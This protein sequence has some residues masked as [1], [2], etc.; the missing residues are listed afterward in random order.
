MHRFWVIQKSAFLASALAVLS[1][2]G[3]ASLLTQAPLVVPP[4]P[5]SFSYTSATATYYVGSSI[6]PNTN[7]LTTP[8]AYTYSSTPAL[9]TGLS[10]DPT[11]GNI[12]GIPQS[13]T[14]AGTYVITATGPDVQFAT[15]TIDTQLDVLTTVLSFVNAGTTA[16]PVGVAIPVTLTTIDPT[17]S[18]FTFGGL[19]VTF[20]VDNSAGG[21]GTLG[22]VTDNLDG[23]YTVNF[24]GMVLGDATI[25][26]SIGGTAI[27]S[28]WTFTVGVGP[29][30]QLAF[31]TQ[32][33]AS[34]QS[35][36]AFASQ[37]VIELRDLAGNLC[38]TA[39]NNVTL[40]I[41]NNAGTPAGVLSGTTTVAAVGGIATFAGLSIDKIGVGYT[42][43]ASSGAIPT[44]DSAALDITLGPMSTTVS[45]FV[46]DVPTVPAD[47]VTVANLTATILDA[48]GNPITGKDVQVTPSRAGFDIVT[49]A[50]VVTTNAS[51][52]ANFT[53]SSLLLG[54]GNFTA[55]NTTDSLT[56]ATNPAVTFTPGGVSAMLSTVVPSTMTPTADGLATTTVTVT[57]VDNFSNPVPGKTVILTSNRGPFDI[58]TTVAP[59]TGI[60]DA[61]GQVTFT[62]SSTTAGNSQL[63]ATDVTDSLP[64][65]SQPTL[66]FAP[67]TPSAAIS[68]LTATPTT[69][70]ADGVS[71][72]TATVTL[73]DAFSNPVPGKV[74]MLTST[75]GTVTPPVGIT[76]PTGAVSFSISSLAIG[77][78]MLAALDLTDSVALAANPTLTFTAGLPDTLASTVSVTPTT[79]LADGLTPSIVTVTLRDNLGNVVP[80]KTVSL[81]SDR[82]IDTITPATAVTNV[83]G[84]ALFA[85]RST[86]VGTS[87]YTATDTTDSIGIFQTATVTYNAAAVDPFT[88]TISISPATAPADGTL[89]NITVTLKDASGNVVA[90]KTVDVTSSRPPLTDT[91]SAPA[92]TDALGQATFTVSSLV[93]G[94]PTLTATDTT[95]SITVFSTAAPV[96]T[97]PPVSPTLSSV[98]IVPGS[99]VADG[100]LAT[101]TVT[102]LDT[103][104]NPVNGKT[105][106]ISSSRGGTDSISIISAVTAGAGQATFSI[107]SLMT[108]TASI[109]AIDVTDSIS[110]TTPGSV[111]FT[112]GPT[113][114]T[115]ST[116]S[117]TPLSV[118]VGASTSNVTVTL[119]D[120]NG[121][122]IPGVPVQLTSTGVATTITP[123]APTNTDALGVVTFT[124][125][126][127]TLGTAT[128]TA[129][130]TATPT[131]ISSSNPVITF[132]VG[133]TDPIASTVVAA[134][135]TVAADGATTSTITV[136]LRDSVGNP[137]AGKTVTLASS[138]TLGLD[139]IAPASAGSDI[140]D[141]AGVATFTVLSSTA[142]APDFFA[143]NATDSIAIT[144][145]ATVTFTAGA[146]SASVS[147][148]TA[149]S[150]TLAGDSTATSNLT[151][152]LKDAFGNPV[153]GKTV[154]VTSSRLSPPDTISAPVV[155]NAL[156]Q[157]TFTISANLV[158]TSLLTANDV[159]DGFPLSTTITLT[160]VPGAVH[161]GNST[162]TASLGSIPSDGIT[163][164]IITVTLRD[165]TGN[166]VPGKTV[167]TS[168]SRAGSDTLAPASAVTNAL[169]VANFSL[170]S[171]VPGTAIISAIGDLIPV[172]ATVS[173]AVNP[174]ITN[175]ITSTVT[176]SSPFVFADGIAFTTVTVTCRDLLGN[177]VPGST[178]TLASSRGIDMIAPASAVTNGAGVAS[179]QVSSLVSGAST[180]TATD[181]TSSVVILQTAAT[182]F[183]AGAPTAANS[184]VLATTATTVTADG[185]T[186]VSITVNLKDASMN[187]VAG[188]VVT[189]TSDR[190]AFDTIS[191]ALAASDINGDAFFTVKSAV[192]G[193]SIYSAVSNPGAIAITDNETATYTPGLTSASVSTAV[194]SPTSLLADGVATSTILVTI[195][196]AQSNVKPGQTVTISSDRAGLDTFPSGTS[197][198]TNASGQVSFTVLS[199]TAGLS[200]YTITDTTDGIPLSTSP[201]VTF[202]PGVTDAGTSTVVAAPATIKAD[203]T[204]TATVTVTLRD[205][206]SNLV[207]GKTVTL[208]SNRVEDTISP[209]S[210]VSDAAGVATFTVRSPRLGTATLTATDTTSAVVVTM[211]GS[212]TFTASKLIV[213][214]VANPINAD[215]LTDVTVTAQDNLGNTDTTYT[216]TVAFTSSDAAATLPANYLFTGPDA[217]VHTFTMMTKF[218]TSGAQSIT[219]TDTIDATITGS[220][221]FSVT[222]VAPSALTYFDAAPL[223]VVLSAIVPNTVTYSGGLVTNF[224]VSPALPAGLTLNAT[225]GV[226][227]GT[228]T[229]ALASAP[230]TITATNG[231]GFTTAVLNIATNFACGTSPGAMT[232]LPYAAGAGTPTNPYLLCSDI[233]VNQIGLN[234]SD[235]GASFK[236][237]GNI[238]LSAYDALTAPTTLALIG[239]GTY[240][241]SPTTFVPGT[242]FTGTFDGNGFTLSNL[243]IREGLTSNAAGLFRYTDGATIQN[244]TLSGIDV[245]G[246]AFVGGLIGYAKRTTITNVT[247][248]GQVQ[249]TSGFAN[250]QFAGGIAAFLDG[251]GAG[252]MS[253]VTGST[254]N[255]NVTANDSVGAVAGRNDATSGGTATI[256]T[257]SS[258]GN[259]AAVA[260]SSGWTFGGLVGQNIAG[261]GTA[262]VTTCTSNATVTSYGRFTG[263]LLGANSSSA[264]GNATVSGSAATGAVT[265][266]SNG[267]QHVGGLIGTNSGANSQVVSSLSTSTIAVNGTA[268]SFVGGL[269][270][271]NTPSAAG[272]TAVSL[273]YA[274][275]GIT[276]TG[277]NASS[278][279]GLVGL[280]TGSSLGSSANISRSYST[281]AVG[282]VSAGGNKV[283]GLIG[284][285]IAGSGAG[286]GTS[287]LY[288][289]Y[290]TST[291]TFGAGPA[292]STYAG[293]FVGQNINAAITD[294][295][296]RGNITTPS[297][298]SIGG[299]VGSNVAGTLTNTYASGSVTGTSNLGGLIGSD[300]TGVYTA[301]YW[302]SS[303]TATGVGSGPVAGTTGLSTGNM[304]L[305][306]NFIGWDFTT[307]WNAPGG[308]YLIL[309]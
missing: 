252:N 176:S 293:G 192:A 276:I 298:S 145:P 307:I 261:S 32:P 154:S 39:T 68:T 256:A 87:I 197:L 186:T 264:G 143:T 14:A 41:G 140:S 220:Q 156:G 279:G 149:S 75:L 188:Q 303:I 53:V 95:D 116:I 126:S 244:L 62:I 158:G 153:S 1:A 58:I 210:A 129:T 242:A 292:A 266:T 115:V 57:L 155:T 246:S 221:S 223:Y 237:M 283:G 305:Q 63:T 251:S 235:W 81:V 306:A 177:V 273:S 187:N 173:V 240:T 275:G 106:S 288:R 40:A 282:I 97:A 78:A 90:G 50:G 224:S 302:D 114:A 11:T 286:A 109:S 51:G 185:V 88:S 218:I 238:D 262:T 119:R 304:Y 49:P 205:I 134:P 295:Y 4:G 8:A 215:T 249:D 166:V 308:A 136:T 259:V 190:G 69:L 64:L 85:V 96:F 226:I 137:V 146:V 208:A 151:V 179:F 200:T 209:A 253:S 23:T 229:I 268:V 28:S 34:T 123:A 241:L 183:T 299:L 35:A 54:I 12:I 147:T 170:T 178:V 67:G 167:T 107:S 124:V 65:T 150:T 18:Q 207:S 13:L 44:S 25:T 203:D 289:S 22:A 80:G 84:V 108:G 159:T 199:S 285:N 117:A 122:V 74:V 204:T 36:T 105:V 281:G 265:V 271:S 297:G 104:S 245:E 180:F 10:I 236:M 131:I 16:A 280:N 160:W 47:G 132:V 300:V 269:L 278:I 201:T 112:P 99:I 76:G 206:T 72:S 2:C 225:T 19:P 111:S 189:L 230:Y 101:V 222:E 93:A 214:G 48:G 157:A 263:G 141:A 257:T 29:P 5:L 61:L 213:A 202:S 73:L 77:T 38:T 110:I 301:N 172:T 46:S 15:V 243:I 212:V 66:A 290:S 113:S 94:T 247:V 248:A 70:F 196:D 169:G 163:P 42:L 128:L 82:G 254:A 228:P 31:T 272:T 37:P 193:T 83:A 20:A 125:S 161:A 227:T 43:R 291:V 52:V 121:N 30:A 182:T 194:A 130:E 284:Q 274:T 26:A 55:N 59:V 198:V 135:I 152:T 191:P 296:A 232:N 174:G 260:A 127:V 7:N 3:G 267:V 231:A 144:N 164:S 216:G 71:T 211:T 148:F 181:T 168:S 294:S 142:G 102:L 91:I 79:Q 234:P 98:A 175:A 239:T 21:D 277:I 250:T 219:A 24:T 233:Q 139:T 165:A 309:Q 33:S 92:V 103:L 89:I 56:V 120:A 133:P 27:F 195:K 118:G 138:R 100:T 6:T 270:G 17:L 45:T 184:T 287:T 258:S 9:P 86:L 60:S 255:V 217:G 171:L 162:V